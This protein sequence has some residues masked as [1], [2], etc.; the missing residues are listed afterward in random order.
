M[1]NFLLNNI[2]YTIKLSEE[3][4]PDY[5]NEN[6]KINKEIDKEL[7]DFGIG[8]NKKLKI[9]ENL[10]KVAGLLPSKVIEIYVS[11]FY[12]K[13]VN[14]EKTKEI[15]KVFSEA[16]KFGK[17]LLNI[18]PTQ[19]Y[20]VFVYKSILPGGFSFRF[21]NPYVAFP[22]A[23]ADSMK[24][25]KFLGEYLIGHEIAHLYLSHG[26]KRVGLNTLL[27]IIL[28]T[29]PIIFNFIINKYIK[30]RVEKD[31]KFLTKQQN[32]ENYEEYRK[33]N[34]K[35]K[36]EVEQEIR[37][38]QEKGDFK[39]ILQI[40]NA[41]EQIGIKREN[42]KIFKSKSVNILRYAII[43]AY[44][45]FSQQIFN[46]L[47]NSVSRSQETEADKFALNFVV[48]LNGAQNVNLNDIFDFH[49][50]PGFNPLK[51]ATHPNSKKRIED[52]FNHA[53]KLGVPIKDEDLK[54][55]TEQYGVNLE[56]FIDNI[57]NTFLKRK[58]W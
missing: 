5:V 35:T 15:N 21:G 27:F 52:L 50:N 17:D 1:D 34:K 10:C 31:Q 26:E 8:N 45:I 24:S 47:V 41:V 33:I 12:E 20:F 39:N 36:E 13:N 2:F 40:Q 58:K 32:D 11:V 7:L 9:F 3:K 30:K 46:S 16:I 56:Y 28:L 38:S 23:T 4:L 22:A 6:S 44:S 18:K 54:K 51:G 19:E 49:I 43:F 55:W 25:K 48:N 42:Y 14:E 53:V 57:Q 37:E 29:V